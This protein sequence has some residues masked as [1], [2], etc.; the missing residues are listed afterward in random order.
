MRTDSGKK[1]LQWL[2]SDQNEEPEPAPPALSHQVGGHGQ[3]SV[4][5]RSLPRG[6]FS[7]CVPVCGVLRS[8]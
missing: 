8:V 3:G 5:G 6:P 2:L 4:R 7:G 1:E